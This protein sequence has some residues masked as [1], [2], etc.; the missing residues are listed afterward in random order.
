M[1]C[2]AK[3]VRDLLQIIQVG[4]LQLPHVRIGFS[5]CVTEVEISTI[6]QR[7]QQCSCAMHANWRT[8]QALMSCWLVQICTKMY[9][10]DRYICK[11]HLN[12]SVVVQEPS[13]LQSTI[14]P[15]WRLCLLTSLDHL[16]VSGQAGEMQVFSQCQSVFKCVCGKMNK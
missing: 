5:V 9:T 6:M 7:T 15:C 10:V 1:K 2:V 8:M 11:F 14:L 12:V 13:Q 3:L 16:C 4:K